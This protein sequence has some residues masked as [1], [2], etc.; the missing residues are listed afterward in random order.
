MRNHRYSGRL[1]A[2]HLAMAREPVWD[3]TAQVASGER[4]DDAAGSG[5]ADLVGAR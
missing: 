2:I 5:R 4:R 1:D 3:S